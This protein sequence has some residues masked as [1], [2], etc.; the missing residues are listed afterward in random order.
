VNFDKGVVHVYASK[1]KTWREIDISDEFRAQLLAKKAEADEELKEKAARRAKA[2]GKA[3]G[4]THEQIAEVAAAAASE[5]KSVYIIE[6]QGRP[7]KC[8]RSSFKAALKKAGITYPV[9]LY[10]IRH[11][12]ASVMLSKGADLA[13]VSGLMGHSSIQQTANTYYELMAGEKKRAIATLPSLLEGE[14]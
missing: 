4:W 10:D 1:T 6:F 5:A 2:E 12:F 13:A 11:L 14:P 3:K 7:V 9:R 8:L